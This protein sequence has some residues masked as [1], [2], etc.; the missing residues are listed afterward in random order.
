LKF[1]SVL[2]ALSL[3][4]MPLFLHYKIKFPGWES[5]GL[6]QATETI[7]SLGYILSH[8]NQKGGAIHMIGAIFASSAT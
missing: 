8:Y 1:S 3:P 6:K 4:A 2:K 7:I 5:H